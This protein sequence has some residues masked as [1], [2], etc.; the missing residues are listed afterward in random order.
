MWYMIWQ[1]VDSSIFI[2]SYYLNR[3]VWMG[4]LE[5]EGLARRTFRDQIGAVS[6]K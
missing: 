5:G 3:K 1:Y 6:E 4:G 2:S